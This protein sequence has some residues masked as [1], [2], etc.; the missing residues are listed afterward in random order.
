MERRLGAIEGTMSEVV[1]RMENLRM[2]GTTGQLEEELKE[3]IRTLKGEMRDLSLT[4]KEPKRKT[5]LGKPKPFGGE[6]KELRGFLTLMD[7]HMEEEGLN[8]AKAA[9]KIRFVATYLIDDAWE[10]FEPIL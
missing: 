5:K 8:E 9:D 6:P 10:W 1:Q 3:G 7:L 2:E 4:V